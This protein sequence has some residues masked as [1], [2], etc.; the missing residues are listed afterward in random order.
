MIL[1]GRTLAAQIRESLPRRAEAVCQKLGR[2]IKLCAIGSTEDYGAYVYLKKEVEAARKLG[3]ETQVFE[4][5]NQ[6]PAAEFLALVEKLSADDKTDA[7]LIPRPLPDHLAATDFA[8]RLAPQKDIDGM[9]NI[10]TGNLF[11]CKT[12]PEIQALKGFVA[13]T[14]MAVIRL[15]T[16]HHVA[17]EGAEAAV[18]GRSITVGRPLAHLLTCQNATVKICHTK[19]DLPRALKDADLVCSAAGTP[20]LIEADWLRPGTTVVDISTNWHNDSLCGD[21]D[22]EKL[23]AR[24]I[25]YSPVPGGVGPVTLAVLLENIILSGERKLKENK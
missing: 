20:G 9:S 18:I 21:A 11:L 24:G 23:Q 16:Y 15:L 14:A 10:N 6:T 13:C 12:W 25:S 1:E 22:P 5:N 17:L 7:I 4:I 3:V 2:P 19:T 8:D